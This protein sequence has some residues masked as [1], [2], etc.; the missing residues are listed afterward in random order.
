[1]TQ[2][3]EDVATLNRNRSP[4]FLC[5]FIFDTENILSEEQR[6]KRKLRP[7]YMVVYEKV[8]KCQ[9]IVKSE[10]AKQFQ[11]ALGLVPILGLKNRTNF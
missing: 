11:A 5:L 3:T 1:M 2:T 6:K 7:F 9:R 10:S 4:S 8:R